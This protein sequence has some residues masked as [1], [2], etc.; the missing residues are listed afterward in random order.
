VADTD[1]RYEY[2]VTWDWGAG[3]LRDYCG[4][5]LSEEDARRNLHYRIDEYRQT[6][7][8]IERRTVGEWTPIS[9]ESDDG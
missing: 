3:N 9:E 8:R 5:F 6:G 4:P 2:R 7:L 1:Q